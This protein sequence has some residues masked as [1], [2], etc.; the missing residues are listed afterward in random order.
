MF[1]VQ[2]FGFNFSLIIA[3]FFCL[4]RSLV[5]NWPFFAVFLF[6]DS[7]ISLS[8]YYSYAVCALWLRLLL[9]ADGYNG[10]VQLAATKTAA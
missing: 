3:F 8:E 4:V 6:L 7:L 5:I 9:L 1:V 10:N 2:V